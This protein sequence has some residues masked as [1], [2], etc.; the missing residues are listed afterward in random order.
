[1]SLSPPGELEPK[2]ARSESQGSEVKPETG[3]P[4]E[5]KK[6]KRNRQHKKKDKW[7]TLRELNLRVLSK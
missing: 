1:M 4:E 6:R 3:V 7:S 5:G 2:V